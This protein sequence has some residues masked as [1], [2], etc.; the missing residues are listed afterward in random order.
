MPPGEADE[1]PKAASSKRPKSQA[2]AEAWA[3]TS[4][5]SPSSVAPTAITRRSPKRSASMPDGSM[6]S[7]IPPQMAE[8]SSPSSVRLSPSSRVRIGPMAAGVCWGMETPIWS[9]V[10]SPST[11]QR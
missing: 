10:A 9:T 5:T 3:A 1:D 11:T 4:S 7:S 2:S 8:V 6:P